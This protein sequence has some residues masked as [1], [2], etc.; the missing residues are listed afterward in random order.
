[1]GH[2]SYVLLCTET[3]L[4][5]PP[6]VQPKSSCDVHLLRSPWV[7]PQKD[8]RAGFQLIFHNVLLHYQHHIWKNWRPILP[9]Y[10]SGL[11][12]SVR[13]ET[14]IWNPNWAV[15]FGH[16]CTRGSGWS[17]KIKAYQFESPNIKQANE[18]AIGRLLLS[19][20]VPE[21]Q[22]ESRLIGLE[23]LMA[24]RSAA[25]VLLCSI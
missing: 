6:V 10:T 7:S 24:P 15:T 19:T 11:S 1:M 8:T 16:Q 12:H 3:T 25:L 5:N 17:V 9:C 21:D 2:Q 4:S 14:C 13:W 18:I 20:S 23:V 22:E